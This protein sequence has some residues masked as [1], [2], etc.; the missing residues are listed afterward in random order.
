MSYKKNSETF[1]WYQRKVG[2]YKSFFKRSS[3][4]FIL[5]FFFTFKGLYLLQAT[6]EL[7]NTLI[8]HKIIIILKKTGGKIRNF[9]ENF[10]YYE[11]ISKC[12]MRIQY[13]LKYSIFFM[14]V[15]FRYTNKIVH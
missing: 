5:L 10:K 14:Q 6:Y 13:E 3:D 8:T 12:L 1:E 4:L 11:K 2:F 7:W 9:L 15:C